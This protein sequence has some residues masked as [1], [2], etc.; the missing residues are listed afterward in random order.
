MFGVGPV[1]PRSLGELEANSVGHWPESLVTA[2]ASASV[3]P[4]L[5]KTQDQFISILNISDRSPLAWRDALK[6]TQSLPP[7]LFLKHLSVLTDIGGEKIVHLKKQFATLPSQVLRFSWQGNEESYRLESVA[8]NSA[9]T[10]AALHIDG[11][12]LSEA[13]SLTPAMQDVCMILLWG[14]SALHP[15]LPSYLDKCEVGSMLGLADELDRYVRQRYIHVSRITAGADANAI[16]HLCQSEVERALVAALPG[17]KL[18]R[19]IPGVRAGRKAIDT[20]FDIVLR[21]PAGKYAVVEVSFQV[22]TNSVI[23]RKAGQAKDRQRLLHKHGHVIAYVLDGAGN[24]R[25]RTALQTICDF[26]DC[27]VTF[28]G[29]ELNRLADFLRQRG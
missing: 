13:A 25:R 22:T 18:S 15:G 19:S 2:A 9:W 6:T 26:S 3:I 1:M 23:E 21:S 14:G 10:N 29:D 4:R 12:G 28:R 5:I 24:F 7:N 27:T 11:A 16:G 20:E 17:W 8:E